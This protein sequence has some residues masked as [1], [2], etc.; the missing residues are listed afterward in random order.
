MA[1]GSEGRRWA[2]SGSG[3]KGPGK[4]PFTLV[5]TEPEGRSE[6]G[7]GGRRARA[8]S[9]EGRSIAD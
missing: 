8:A 6:L 4:A 1:R 5:A 7:D 3:N 2:G 9:I